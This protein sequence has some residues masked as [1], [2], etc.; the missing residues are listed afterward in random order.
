MT[1]YVKLSAL[2]RIAGAK[3]NVSELDEANLRKFIREMS[4]ALTLFM[5]IAVLSSIGGDDDDDGVRKYL[6]NQM[7]RL[8]RDLTTYMNPSSLASIIKNPMPVVSSM[9]DIFRVGD[10]AIKSSI[11]GDPYVGSGEQQRLRLARDIERNIPFVNQVNKLIQK[12]DR[13]ITY[14]Y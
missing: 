7:I 12:F 6:L 2:G 1:T 3:P 14:T 9:I 13:E 5:L 10:S 8:Q 11:F 4:F